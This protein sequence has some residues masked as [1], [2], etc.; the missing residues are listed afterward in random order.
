[1]QFH[2]NGF[3]PGD[4]SEPEPAEQFEGRQDLVALPEEVDVLIVGC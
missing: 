1:M 4:P 2:L 3:K